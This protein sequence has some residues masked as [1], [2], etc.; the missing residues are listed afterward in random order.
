MKKRL[1]S[2]VVAL[3]L[4]SG[5][6]FAASRAYIYT[7]TAAEYP[8]MFNGDEINFGDAVPMVYAGRTMVPLRG[9]GSLLGA[10]VSWDGTAVQVK[11]FDVEKLKDACVMVRS[12]RRE[13]DTT[14]VVQ[15]SGVL[16]DYDKILTAYHVVGGNSNYMVT[17]DDSD[18]IFECALN[19]TSM[20]QDAAILTPQDKTKK[21]AKLGD[22]DEVVVGDRVYIVNCPKGRKNVVDSG[23]VT[24][25]NV[26]IG[27]TSRIIISTVTQHGSSGGAVF[28]SKGE[29]IGIINAG[30]EKSSYVVPINDLRKALAN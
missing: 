9:L 26:I 6:A 24:D 19:D 30:N 5:T 20:T 25:V 4:L 23:T 15:G 22:S 3:C 28:N 8:I 7:L 14:Y 1:I 10:T 2:F 11:T 18:L 29:L 17:Y 16:I 12:T 27:S 13:G 21:P